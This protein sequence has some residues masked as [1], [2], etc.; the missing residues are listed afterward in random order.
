MPPNS[1][2]FAFFPL[3]T[4]S[5]SWVS[6]NLSDQMLTL[7]FV[8]GVPVCVLVACGEGTFAGEGQKW[9]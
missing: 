7:S 8:C 1:F 9:M 2:Y 6:V 5:L 3:E 4:G